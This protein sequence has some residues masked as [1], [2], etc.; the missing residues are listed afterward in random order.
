M[1]LH[2]ERA[3]VVRVAMRL[4]GTRY[5][6]GGTSPHMGFDCSGLTRF[7]YRHLGIAL[8]HNAAAQF[9]LGRRV[10]AGQ[11]RPGDLLFFDG[12]G[13][14]GVYIGAGKFIHAPRAG[15][16]VRISALAGW[17]SRAFDGARRFI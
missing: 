13:H 4:L 12:L 10:S 5:V 17:W 6:Y 8:P 14:V 3:E 7:V 1:R 15:E 11:L 9:Q 2:R 16:R